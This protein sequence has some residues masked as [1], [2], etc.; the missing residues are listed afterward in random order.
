MDF[1]QKIID[2][3][4]KS[5]SDKQLE[6]FSRLLDSEDLSESKI[7][8]FLVQSGIDIKALIKA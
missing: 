4:I 6:S 1:N 3:I 2:R 7:S 5:L 8:D